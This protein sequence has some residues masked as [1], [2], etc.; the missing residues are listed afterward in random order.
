MLISLQSPPKTLIE[1]EICSIF[2]D[3]LN[4]SKHII[5]RN[6]GFIDIGG[7]SFNILSK[8]IVYELS[9]YIEKLLNDKNNEKKIEI[10][11]KCGNKEFPVTSQ[12]LGMYIDSIKNP[13]SIVYNIPI[14]FKK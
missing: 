12:Q 6:S 13:K 11:E 8:P 14:F 10:I 4:I 1:K 3:S 7:D 2:S 9:E 5:G